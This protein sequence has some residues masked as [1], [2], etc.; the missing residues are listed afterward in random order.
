[1][2]ASHLSH[3]SLDRGPTIVKSMP[4]GRVPDPGPCRGGPLGPGLGD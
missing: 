2:A 1:M 3:R 4:A